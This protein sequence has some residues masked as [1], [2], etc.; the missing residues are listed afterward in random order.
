M[1]LQNFNNSGQLLGGVGGN[2]NF[3]FLK[4]DSLKMD[5][6]IIPKETGIFTISISQNLS[7]NEYIGEVNECKDTYFNEASFD[8]VNLAIDDKN[9]LLYDQFVDH[10]YKLSQDLYEGQAIITFE[11]IE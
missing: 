6:N 4:E 7:V 5:L 2:Y 1:H 10:E 8:F 11:V 9:Y 3:E